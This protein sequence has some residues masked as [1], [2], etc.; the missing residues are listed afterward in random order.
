MNFIM[1]KQGLRKAWGGATAG[2]IATHIVPNTMF[3]NQLKSYDPYKTPDSTGSVALAKAAMK[4]SKYDT[5]HDGTCSAPQCKN[6][7]MIADT[8]HQ[9]TAMVPVIQSAA[10]KIGITFTVRTVNGAYP[11]I[12][13]PRKNVPISERPGWGK[14]YADPLTFF[15]PLFLSSS[16]IPS[17]NVNYA[18]VG[19]TPAIA[20]KIGVTGNVTGVPSIDADFNKCAALIEQA[21]FTCW[22]QLDK[23]MMTQVVPWVPYLDATTAKVTGPKVTKWNWD[24]FSGTTAYAHVAVS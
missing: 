8:R 16:I 22:E 23:K 15:Q 7:L 3:N 20:K 4:G 10:S 14:D 21:R 17:G 13:T 11:V 24:Q 2:N 6:I 5:N 9:D 12:Q 18:L 1:D 19:I